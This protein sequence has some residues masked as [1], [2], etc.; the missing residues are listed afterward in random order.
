[1]PNFLDPFLQIGQPPAPVRLLI[2][3]KPQARKI[4]HQHHSNPYPIHP[5]QAKMVG[6][7]PVARIAKGKID[8]CTKRQPAP[9]IGAGADQRKMPQEEKERYPPVHLQK[10][11]KPVVAPAE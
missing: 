1:M 4:Q 6:G 3:A 5:P 9:Y 2:I 11:R 10:S 7:W 8:G